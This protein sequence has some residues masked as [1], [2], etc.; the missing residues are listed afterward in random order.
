MRWTGFAGYD[1]AYAPVASAAA[2]TIVRRA[3]RLMES[4]RLYPDF[5]HDAAPLREL[6]PDEAACALGRIAALGVEAERRQALADFR[7][8]QHLVDLAVHRAHDTR[9]RAARCDEREPADELEAREGLRDRRDVLVSGDGPREGL[10][11]RP[12]VAAPDERR[13]GGHGEHD[14]LRAPRERVLH[15][16]GH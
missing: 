6:A 10:G 12:Q 8:L 4:L 16:L 3:C 2:T 13:G 11:D 7:I 14:E 5:L 1:W 9:G 15:A